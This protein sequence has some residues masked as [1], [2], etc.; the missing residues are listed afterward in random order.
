MTRMFKTET[1]RFIDKYSKIK[2][3]RMYFFKYLY[4]KIYY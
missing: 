1:V 2:E 4:T 3:S